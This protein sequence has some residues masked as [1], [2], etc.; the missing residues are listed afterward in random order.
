MFSGRVGSG[1][2]RCTPRT[3]QR[4]AFRQCGRDSR[5]ASDRWDFETPARSGAAL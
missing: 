4:S 3:A 1:F 2:N 5:C